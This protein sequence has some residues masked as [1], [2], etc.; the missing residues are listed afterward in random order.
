MKKLLLILMVVSGFSL[1][2]H[3][4]DSMNK[5]IE[6]T[7]DK[8]VKKMDNTTDKMNKKI[9]NK[10]KQADRR[11]DTTTTRTIPKTRKPKTR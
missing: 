6:N 5:K 3:A 2:V 10:P 9:E 4:Q 7:T 8:M 11:V 1:S